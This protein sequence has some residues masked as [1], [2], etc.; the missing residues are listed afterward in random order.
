MDNAIQAAVSA[1]QE[2]FGATPEK[3]R[4]ETTLLIAAD[5]NVE[6]AAALRD[7]F[8]FNMLSDETAVDYWPQESPRFHVVYQLYSLPNNVSLRL[9]VPLDGNTPRLRTLESVYPN[10]NWYER[11]VW[12]L[13][14]IRFD[15]HSDPRRIMMPH[16][17]AGHPLRKDYPLGY[18]E[19]QFTFNFKEIDL[20]KPKGQR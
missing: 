3:S 15:G 7:E 18:E 5:Q 12:D 19:Q 1:M 2:R 4:G 20:R 14:G 9:R 11:E 16:D 10:A 13:F 6:I 8:K 17:W